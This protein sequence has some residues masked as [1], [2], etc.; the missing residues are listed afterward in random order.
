MMKIISI[1][2]YWIF[3]VVFSFFNDIGYK[4]IGFW[5]LGTSF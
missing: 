5:E 1:L 2:T 3:P 4:S